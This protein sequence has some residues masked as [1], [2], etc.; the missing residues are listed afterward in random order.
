LRPRQGD[1]S[2]HNGT[3]HVAF[4]S[5]NSLGPRDFKDFVAQSHTPNDHCVRFAVV[6]TFPDAT[7]VTRRALPLT[8]A[9]LSPAGSRQLRLAHCYSFTAGDFLHILLASLP[10][11]SLALRPAHSRG[12][13][14]VTAIRRLQPFR[15]LHDCSDCF[16]LERIAGWAL[17]PL[18]SAAFSRRTP[19]AVILASVN[20]SPDRRVGAAS[21]SIF[22]H[23]GAAKA[24]VH[25]PRTERQISR[26]SF[27]L[28]I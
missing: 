17:H 13:Q 4:G 25:C 6:V 12:H 1:G 28:A 9:G 15:Y 7:L 23:A 2:S 27:P 20:G 5:S 14:V 21:P 8:W 3:A 22:R 26:V 19:K 10:A 18:E 24:D 16:R 11:H